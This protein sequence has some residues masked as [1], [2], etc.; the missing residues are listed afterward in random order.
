MSEKSQLQVA[1]DNVTDAKRRAATGLRFTVHEDGL[2]S[3]TTADNR[4]FIKHRTCDALF[5]FGAVSEPDTLEDES[6]PM[7]HR[8]AYGGLVDTFDMALVAITMMAR[9]SK[10]AW[11]TI[12]ADTLTC[13][14]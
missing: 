6:L 3:V 11:P 13:R 7:T 2:E 9:T 12:S 10:D 1:F 8:I 5:L 4:F 14:V